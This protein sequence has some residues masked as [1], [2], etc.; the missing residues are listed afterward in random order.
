MRGRDEREGRRERGRGQEREVGSQGGGQRVN[1]C[2][3]DDCHSIGAQLE[4]STGV[5]CAF[6]RAREWVLESV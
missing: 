3:R 6:M 4:A 2:E 5:V 1:G